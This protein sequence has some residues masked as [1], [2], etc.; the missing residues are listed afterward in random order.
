VAGG[1]TLEAVGEG[2]INFGSG[3]IFKN[4]LF[5]PK[6]GY[7]LLSVPSIV[8]KNM[9]VNF[10][11]SSCKIQQSGQT[12]LKAAKFGDLY[13]INPNEIPSA[14]YLS[15]KVKNELFHSRFGHFGQKRLR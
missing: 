4:V 15:S 11:K 10:D 9:S 12:I 2:D 8:Q 7:N 5:L 3:L 13:V 6:L 1:S 14:L